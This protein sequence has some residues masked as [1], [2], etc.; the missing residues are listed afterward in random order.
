MALPMIAPAASPSPTPPQPQP[1]RHCTV[2]TSGVDASRRDIDAARGTA[3]ADPAIDQAL[4]AITAVARIFTGKRIVFLLLT[5]AR[6]HSRAQ[7]P[8]VLIEDQGK[9][10]RGRGARSSRHLLPAG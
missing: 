9:N 7:C 10:C 8:K 3:P 2:S 5:I 6:N 4:P 1:R